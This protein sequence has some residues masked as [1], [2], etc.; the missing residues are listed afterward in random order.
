MMNPI[1]IKPEGSKV[2][3]MVA[4]SAKIENGHVHLPKDAPW[5]GAFLQELLGFPNG[6]NDDQVDSVSQLLVW[7]QRSGSRQM[8]FVPPLHVSRPRLIP[9]Q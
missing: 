6:P 5:L 8:T 2:E 4:Q 1:P 7:M 9:G 3:R